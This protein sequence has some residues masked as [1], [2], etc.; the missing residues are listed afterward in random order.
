MSS[1]HRKSPKLQK[2]E[3]SRRPAAACPLEVLPTR[4]TH[5]GLRLE[6][7]VRWRHHGQVHSATLDSLLWLA[8]V[9]RE[10]YPRDYPTPASALRAAR[11]RTS[12]EIEQLSQMFPEEMFPAEAA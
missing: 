5:N 4:R 2:W 6:V 11:A 3:Q 9:L 7:A 8:Q 1:S 12:W 10:L